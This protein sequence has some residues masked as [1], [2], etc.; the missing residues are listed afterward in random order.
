M[1][2]TKIQQLFGVFNKN[3]SR[4]E[5][6]FLCTLETAYL[7]KIL[8]I[9]LSN[10]NFMIHEIYLGLVLHFEERD[11]P[12]WKPPEDWLASQCSS[13]LGRQRKEPA[14]QEATW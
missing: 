3:N 11:Q 7:S 13:R 5:P 14:A 9:E 12:S 10:I 6:A 2:I 1:N 8:N 4:Q